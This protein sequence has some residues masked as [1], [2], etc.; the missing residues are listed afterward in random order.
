MSDFLQQLVIINSLSYTH[1]SRAFKVVTCILANPDSG[2][3]RC[4]YTE[5]CISVSYTHLDVYKRQRNTLHRHNLQKQ[6][7]SSTVPFLQAGCG[8]PSVARTR[9]LS[10]TGSREHHT[11]GKPILTLT[12]DMLNDTHNTYRNLAFYKD[13]FDNQRT[14]LNFPKTCK[15][16]SRRPYPRRDRLPI[17]PYRIPLNARAIIRISKK[18]KSIP[19]TT[20]QIFGN[21]S[22]K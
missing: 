22:F 3:T 6:K 14:T 18:M 13:R 20:P 19:I 16:C 9:P 17:G 21:S 2:G 15:Q 8:L 1:G 11:R 12:Q 7:Y 4:M 5:V 10:L